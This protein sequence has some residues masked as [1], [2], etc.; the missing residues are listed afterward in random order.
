MN[1]ISNT[2]SSPCVKNCT[3]RGTYLHS[4]WYCDKLRPF[5]EHIRSEIT[6]ITGVPIPQ[7]VKYCLFN[8]FP[9]RHQDPAI[10]ETIGILLTVAKEAIAMKWRDE[11][12]PSLSLWRNK[13]LEHFVLSKLEF[14]RMEKCSSKA[15]EFFS[16]VWLPI[17]GY[18]NKCEF[19]EGLELY[20]SL[21]YF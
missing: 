11:K 2:I 20:K 7:I 3:K 6:L 18:L 13:L 17:L 10:A 1:K 19:G 16:A 21:R 9:E 12:P 15:F 14:S 4:W 5:W 8:V